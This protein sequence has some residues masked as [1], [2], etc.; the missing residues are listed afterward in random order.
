MSVWKERDSRPEDDWISGGI[1]VPQYRPIRG[2][3]TEKKQKGFR[4]TLGVGAKVFRL[5]CWHFSYMETE[6]ILEIK[7][8]FSSANTGFLRPC[9]FGKCCL[10]SHSMSLPNLYSSHH[11][12]LSCHC[13]SLHLPCGFQPGPSRGT[14]I[15]AFLQAALGSAADSYTCSQT[16]D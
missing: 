5:I 6:I 2:D 13:P 3:A 4:H 1:F 11:S 12:S 14:G 7:A 9:W 16:E 10:M 8:Y 15:P